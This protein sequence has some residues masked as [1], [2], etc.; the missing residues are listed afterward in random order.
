MLAPAAC[1]PL[2]AQRIGLR[3][4]DREGHVLCRG[5]Y[6][7][8]FDHPMRLFRETGEVTMKSRAEVSGR[9]RTESR[10]LKLLLLSF[11]GAAISGTALVGF[12]LGDTLELRTGQIVQGRFVGGSPLNIR[13]EVDGKEQIFATK[14]VLNI[15]FS[16]VSDVSDVSSAPAPPAAPAPPVDSAATPAPTAPI[17]QSAAA[18]LP[19]HSDLPDAPVASSAARRSPSAAQAITIPAGTSLLVRM[20]DGVDSSTSRVGDP[21]QASLESDLVR[22]RHRGRA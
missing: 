17:A 1:V 14:D 20:V 12:A 13:F 16:D 9:S 4:H 22:W 19:T 18:P 6:L 15:G 11:V 2:P 7:V 5:E 8:D 3:Y 21:F 10:L